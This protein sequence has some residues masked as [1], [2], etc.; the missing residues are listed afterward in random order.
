MKGVVVETTQRA[1]KHPTHEQENALSKVIKNKEHFWTKQQQQEEGAYSKDNQH[2]PPTMLTLVDHK[3][4]P[5]RG[6]DRP[7]P[8]TVVEDFAEEMISGLFCQYEPPDPTR[9][10]QK[11]KGI[12]QPA[13][14][15]AR[16]DRSVESYQKRIRWI[17]EEEEEDDP[18]NH[19][20]KPRATRDSAVPAQKRLAGIGNIAQACMDV[21]VESGCVSPTTAKLSSKQQH[22]YPYEDLRTT[23]SQDSSIL[24]P[25]R[26]SRA[27]R[28]AIFDD[29]GNPVSTKSGVLPPPPPPPRPPPN[30]KEVF[31]PQLC[32][33]G[34]NWS[35]EE[36]NTSSN[37]LYGKRIVFHN[38]Q[39]DDDDNSL[40]ANNP[41]AA[42]P[43]PP[44]PPP[45]RESS[46][47]NDLL[48]R[49]PHPSR[50]VVDRNTTN[51]SAPVA[52]RKTASS[53]AG[54]ELVTASAGKTSN[55][56]QGGGNNNSWDD[57]RNR[58][59]ASD[60][61]WDGPDWMEDGQQSDSKDELD[62]H[63][64][65]MMDPVTMDRSEVGVPQI[66][67]DDWDNSLAILP[68]NRGSSS[69]RGRATSNSL[70]P[71]PEDVME[72][73]GMETS[74]VR[75]SDTKADD[76]KK[77]R[78]SL[79]GRGRKNQG[80]DPSPGRSIRRGSMGK[81]S[82]VDDDANNNNNKGSASKENAA[83]WRQRSASIK[84]KL[85]RNKENSS[86]SQS[87][88]PS[89][90]KSL[91]G[92][93][94]FSPTRGSE[95]SKERSQFPSRRSASNYSNGTPRSTASSNN[96]A[97][98]PHLHPAHPLNQVRQQLQGDEAMER[99]SYITAHRNGFDGSGRSS[100]AGEFDDRMSFITAH[101]RQTD[102]D[103]RSQA[104]MSDLDER[105]SYI[106]AHRAQVDAAPPPPP[107]PPPL[108]PADADDR[109]ERQSYIGAHRSMMDSPK[110]RFR[111][112]SPRK[113]LGL[114]LR[115]QDKGRKDENEPNVVVSQTMVEDASP[116]HQNDVQ[117]IQP[118]I[119]PP[120]G[121]Q[122][123]APQPSNNEQV[124]KAKTEEEITWEERTRLAWERIRNGLG[125]ST[126]DDSATDKAN[127]GAEPTN[128]GNS[129]P[130]SSTGLGQQPGNPTTPTAPNQEQNQYMNVP[131]AMGMQQLPTVMT[132]SASPEDQSRSAPD[133]SAPGNNNKPEFIQRTYLQN[134][135]QNQVA[136]SLQ[137]N[138]TAEEQ[139]NAMVASQSAAP[140]PSGYI[141]PTTPPSSSKSPQ[142]QSPRPLKG[143]LKAPTPA[144]KV[145]F[146]ENFDQ[147]FT[148][149]DENETPPD[150]DSQ[151][152]DS[153]ENEMPDDRMPMNDSNNQILT[154]A[155]TQ[156]NL[157]PNQQ[158]QGQAPQQNESKKKKGGF[159]ARRLF[160]IRGKGKNKSSHSDSDRSA[161]HAHGMVALNGTGDVLVHVEPA[162]AEP[163]DAQAPEPDLPTLIERELN[164]RSLSQNE[165]NS[166]DLT[167]N[168]STVASSSTHEDTAIS[169]TPNLPPQPNP[170]ETTEPSMTVVGISEGT[171]P[172][173]AGSSQLQQN[174]LGLQSPSEQMDPT[175]Q[176]SPAITA[177]HSSMDQE[178][179]KAEGRRSRFSLRGR[180]RN[181]ERSK[182]PGRQSDR[183]APPAVKTSNLQPDGIVALSPTRDGPP[184]V[185]GQ[186]QYPV[187][188]PYEQGYIYSHVPY[189]DMHPQQ[190]NINVNPTAGNNTNPPGG[191]MI[192]MMQQ[193]PSIYG[194][195]P[196]QYQ[197]VPFG[198]PY[199]Q[200]QPPYQGQPMVQPPHP[201]QLQ[202]VP[203]ELQPKQQPEPQSAGENGGILSSLAGMF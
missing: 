57:L 134:G 164:A 124:V 41:M 106:T 87:K 169:Q 12:L 150:V 76:T 153:T 61:D 175:G 173:E 135:T 28:Y 48:S 146:M 200:G 44:P 156:L 23:L 128:S 62:S 92:I 111:I 25:Q 31:I 109:L 38:V 37:S 185:V 120:A 113:L 114:S 104:A 189:A 63:G 125:M 50:S 33:V 141:P 152:S 122:M 13:N 127:S 68:Q 100:Q 148:C 203:Q 42:V 27:Q 14:S 58:L 198:A 178:E 74:L 133:M 118:S 91:E 115:S 163:I 46:Q 67:E 6:P 132:T 117:M 181:R 157:V 155:T 171:Q 140:S 158:A 199:V 8:A 73:L 94:T 22:H 129:V 17:D 172:N 103:Q 177:T 182:S 168:P 96:N 18:Y 70:R 16:R 4:G 188:H 71:V 29:E 98:M 43:P 45:K 19:D 183:S 35:D 138:S 79:F 201:Q 154:D 72:S 10:F 39:Y 59:D 89:R 7:K 145:T 55:L 105:L 143:I 90:R 139:Q 56:K 86:R 84:E 112:A 53:S 180:G 190:P 69:A 147:M 131:F 149:V 165:S 95:E 110:R 3:N 187:M 26:E 174:Q 123:A 32:G 101:R 9:R 11:T 24:S 88:S 144:K 97:P 1:I 99:Q 136:V 137:Q 107:P 161:D 119:A 36:N 196:V 49:A 194:Q 166:A 40:L 202:S 81:D 15:F 108:R 186:K 34:L 195:P 116:P 85:R 121:S 192:P 65:M 142:G 176:A 167:P 191:Y 54:A 126:S 47:G 20:S 21:G 82:E 75:I 83:D 78:V 51:Y 30:K 93:T 151:E 170:D 184:F 160:G 77:R 162:T 179:T 2:H 102:G 52:L 60:D 193:H 159:R 5:I 80:R 197:A 130:Q 64:R 66:P